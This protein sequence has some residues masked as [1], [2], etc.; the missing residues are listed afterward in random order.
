[1]ES[2][3]ELLFLANHILA[4]HIHK[5]VILG[6]FIIYMNI[7]LHEQRIKHWG[8]TN[9]EKDAYIQ[10]KEEKAELRKQRDGGSKKVVNV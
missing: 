6:D 3:L 8:D 4:G 10:K 1:M 9:Q 2:Y 5:E 7:K